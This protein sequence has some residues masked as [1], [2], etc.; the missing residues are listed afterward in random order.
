LT[1]TQEEHQKRRNAGIKGGI[2]KKLRST[3]NVLDNYNKLITHITKLRESKSLSSIKEMYQNMGMT[4]NAVD[5]I[6]KKLKDDDNNDIIDDYDEDLN[7]TEFEQVFNINNNA[8]IPAGTWVK[9]KPMKLWVEKQLLGGGHFIDL[10]ETA[11]GKYQERARIKRDKSRGIRYTKRGR[12]VDQSRSSV[13]EF[14]DTIWKNKEK[15]TPIG[16]IKSKD[17]FKT[18]FI[19]DVTW[20]TIHNIYYYGSKQKYTTYTDKETGKLVKVQHFNGSKPHWMEPEYK[21]L[22]KTVYDNGYRE[23]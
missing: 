5:L 8:T 7:Y 17:Q 14:G 9:Y 15:Y 21:E 19:K 2:T 13:D 4:K 16:K 12:E 10:F 22:Y 18:D 6:T 23:V 1:L 3:G 20:G 11:W